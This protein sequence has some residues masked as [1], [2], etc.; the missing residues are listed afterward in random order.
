[1]ADTP[2]DPPAADVTDESG[3]DRSGA[4]A[5]TDTSAAAGAGAGA[6]AAAGAGAVGAHALADSSD[7]SDSTVTGDAG[8]DAAPADSTDSATP[9]TAADPGTSGATGSDT[10]SD[11][12]AGVAVGAGVLGVAGLA[13]AHGSHGSEKGPGG[14]PEGA[15]FGP[16][17]AHPNADGSA[18]G[19]GFTIK[20]NADSMLYHA[21]E[22]PYYV[23]TRAE[24]WFTTAEAAEA[25]G[26]QPWHRNR[27]RAAVQG[28]VQT[29]AF[30]A[31]PYPGSAKPNE[32][33]SAPNPAFMIKGNEDSMLYHLPTSPYYGRTTAQ[34]WFVH[35]SDAKAAGFTAGE[36]K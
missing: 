21:P 2:S 26:F 7:R 24:A 19:D 34:V 23:R 9:A 1:M 36:R 10:G 6:G 20:G 22:S 4:D 15:P 3:A 13:A 8:S 11:T 35:E 18:P 25:A 32:D 17:S 14:R 12:A 27:K 31:G 30:E 28:L 33:G 5:G 16:G 29:P